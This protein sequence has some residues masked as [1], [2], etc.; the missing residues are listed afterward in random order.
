MEDGA[1]E[2]PPRWT[3]VPSIAFY[4]WPEVTDGFKEGDYSPM[5][6]LLDSDLVIIDDIG[7]EYD[8]SKNAANRL[9]QTLSRREQKFTMV[10]TNIHPEHWAHL[11]DVRI[12]DRLLRNSQI[13]D[14]F[15]VP[16]YAVAK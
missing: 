12:A 13:V 9:C 8:P 5:T 4:R 1:G 11:F 6:D 3:R 2:K 15:G 7:A 16:S 14:L 10:T